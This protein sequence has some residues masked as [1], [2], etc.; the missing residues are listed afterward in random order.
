MARSRIRKERNVT[1]IADVILAEWYKILQLGAL[2]GGDTDSDK[3]N[4]RDEVLKRVDLASLSVFLGHRTYR[5][6]V[7]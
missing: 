1:D 2:A 7:R 4:R 3:N 6:A 5:C